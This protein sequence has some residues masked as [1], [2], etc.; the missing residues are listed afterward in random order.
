MSITVVGSIAYDTVKTPFGERERMLG[1]AA[2][3]FALAAAFFDEV[4]V[5]GPVGEDFG[6]QQLD[7]LRAKGV[8]I[9]DIERVAGGKTFFWRGEYG[10]DLNSRE[11][12]DTQLGVFEGF[13]PKLSEGSR[14]SDVLF[15]ANIQ[16]DLQ[17][18]V[19]KQLPD[20][21]FVAL[22]SMNLWIDI[23]R[24]SLVA[25][26]E[27]VDCLILNDAELRQLTGKPNLVSAAREILSWKPSSQDGRGPSVIVAKQGEYGAALITSDNFFA[28]PAYPLET[29]IDPTGAGDT[30][31]GGFVGYIAANLSAG[32]SDGLLR[33]AMAHATVLASF[34]VEQFGTERVERLERAEI[35]ARLRELHAITQ[36]SG[37]S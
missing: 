36:F 4:R 28:L 21:S 12:L 6:E 9:A 24:D 13:E 5:V 27:S 29:V 20:A 33:R 17:L 14:S 30:F 2:V 1:G 31:A 10:W 25:A 8:D 26:I 34:N 7:V 32:L 16:P 11:T 15:L 18:D 3:H 22:D 37:V 35:D 19:R 23:A